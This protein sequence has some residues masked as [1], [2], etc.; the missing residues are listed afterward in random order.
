MKSNEINETTD[1]FGFTMEWLF[2]ASADKNYKVKPVI[3][4]GVKCY[5]TKEQI[6]EYKK[7]QAKKQN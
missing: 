6:K 5:M 7:K 4:D 2:K 3:I 1:N